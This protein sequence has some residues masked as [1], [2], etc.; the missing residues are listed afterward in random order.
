MNKIS[1]KTIFIFL[2]VLVLV[3]GLVI[4]LILIRQRQEIRERAAERGTI[5]VCK[6]IID[7]NGV[8]L[9]GS[10]IPGQSFQISG[11]V[12]NITSED[13]PAGTIGTSNFSVPLAFT[14]DVLND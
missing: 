11:T 3:G 10:A 8:V 4:A 9:D 12:P 1:K 14:D 13:L 6:V 2:G 7:R 5:K